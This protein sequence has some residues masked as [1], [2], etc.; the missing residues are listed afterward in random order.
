M[1]VIP[2]KEGARRVGENVSRIR[3]AFDRE[4]SIH[5]LVQVSRL[6][7]LRTPI[8]AP[9]PFLAS[10]TISQKAFSMES[11]P[12]KEPSLRNTSSS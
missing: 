8:P 5:T 4:V 1:S 10:A 7:E 3:E 9:S 12:S 6:S 11:T 2:R